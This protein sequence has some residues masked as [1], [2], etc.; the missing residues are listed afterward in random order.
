[1]LSLSFLGF[2]TDSQSTI[3]TNNS[4]IHYEVNHEICFFAN[5]K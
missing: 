3:Q 5:G 4:R 2:Q 1:M